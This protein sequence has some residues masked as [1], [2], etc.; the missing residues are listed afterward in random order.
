M[1]VHEFKKMWEDDGAKFVEEDRRQIGKATWILFSLLEPQS[2]I[3]Y[4]R[5]YALILVH[6]YQE[7]VVAHNLKN[8]STGSGK[9]WRPEIEMW[10]REHLAEGLVDP[11]G[12]PIEC[13]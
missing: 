2:T 1:K 8:I 11:Q 3:S 6:D 7:N 4:G 5:H 9:P 10:W 13:A 12:N